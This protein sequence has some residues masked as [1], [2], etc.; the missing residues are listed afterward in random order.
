[1]PKQTNH[2]SG[3]GAERLGHLIAL[4]L[5]TPCHSVA[6]QAFGHGKTDV[7]LTVSNSV[8][9]VTES[10]EI[11]LVTDNEEAA[12]IEFYKRTLKCN[13]EYARVHLMRILASGDKWGIH[14]QP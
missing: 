14:Y 7:V 8:F 11:R 6:Y 13:D 1:M 2:A 3:E 5:V 10:G 9:T 4:G 12:L